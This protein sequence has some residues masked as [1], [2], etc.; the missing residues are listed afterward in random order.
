[1]PSQTEL[2]VDLGLRENLVGITKFCVHPKNLREEI[3]VV[4]GTKDVYFDKIEAL[5]PD[6]IL[7]NKEENT[8]E[9]VRRL[10]EI[11]PVWVSD[12]FTVTDCLVLIYHLG[13]IFDVETRAETLCDAIKAAREDFL[14]F[15][16]DR[17]S[18][19]VLYLIWKNPYMAAGR[20]TFINHLLQLNKFENVILEED[21]RYP[22]VP[23]Q[24]FQ[25]AQI[26]LFSTEPFPFRENDIAEVSA[27][28]NV[29]GRI[30][31]GEYFSWFG[32][33]LIA[34]FE[35]FKTLHPS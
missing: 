21:S 2:L 30:V 27:K 34:A 32:S 12:I 9:M 1:M 5:N 8:P 4:G 26:L 31:D 20:N 22:E 6:F 13:E 29:G 7:C 24:L 10:E 15:I 16:K 28:V 35:Y 14:G 17:P 18:K 3:S 25:R 11:A 33:R 23:L 19:R